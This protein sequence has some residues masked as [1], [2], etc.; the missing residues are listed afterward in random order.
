MFS[1]LWVVRFGLPVVLCAVT[2]LLAATSS[3]LAQKGKLTLR[4]IDESTGALLPARVHLTNSRGKPVLPRGTVRW[5]NHFVIDGEATL[6]LSTGRYTFE[7]EHGPEYRLQ[8]GNF[9]IVPKADDIQT[10]EMVRFVDMKREGWWSG[11]L[12]IHRPPEDVDLLIRAEDLHVAPIITWWNRKNLWANK[13]PPNPLLTKLGQDRWVHW[14]AGE[15]ERGGGAL[16]F[17]NLKKPLEITTA[18]RQF[19]CAVPFIREARKTPG[20]HI[21][22]EKPFWWDV[23]LWLSTGMVDSIGLAH[24]HLWR[25]GMLDNEAWGNPRDKQRYPSPLGNAHWTQE[26]YYHILNCGLKIPPSA[27][28][29]SGVLPNPV[30]YNR[31]YV[32]CGE[33]LSYDKWFE[34]LR[35][36]KVVVTNGPMLRPLVNGKLPGHS[37]TARKGETVTLQPTLKLS[38]RGKIDYLHYIKNG[39]VERSVRL[40]QLRRRLPTVEFNESGWFLIRAVAENGTTY[41]FASTGPYYVEF[42]GGKRISRESTEFFLKWLTERAGQLPREPLEAFQAAIIEY[43]AARDFWQRLVDQANAE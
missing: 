33:E 19:P 17:F 28:S 1:R 40:S 42:D 39:R 35:A 13:Q 6:E 36:G 30:G 27:G 24:N 9:Q 25:D 21:D 7:V 8:T 12:H 29:A 20:V 32:H 41:R 11:E 22:I 18:E 23:P 26:I 37:F 43:R 15:D 5:K 10:L 34:N 31:V 16:L 4:V 3:A 2:M 14:M 38:L